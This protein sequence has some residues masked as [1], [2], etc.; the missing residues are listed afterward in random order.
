MPEQS[1]AII[2]VLG[3]VIGLGLLTFFVVST[4]SFIKIA[5]VLFI[6]RNALGIQQTPPNIIIYGIA[7]ALT[8]FVMSPVLG[9]VS[10]IVLAE[11][12]AP[13]TF[14][15][16]LALFEEAREPVRQFLIRFTPE[17]QREFFLLASQRVWPEGTA[18]PFTDTDF[19]VLIPGFLV[20][21]LQRAFE[22]GF[23]LYLPL[24]VVDLVVTTVLMAMGMSMVTPTIISTPVKLFLFVS[25]SGWTNL[26]EGLVLT[27]AT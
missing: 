20:A 11:E 19:S 1:P 4:T 17:A 8:V 18:Q 24:I 6:V 12:R 16:W 5:V 23:L 26:I 14:D 25:I 15:R 9:E 3:I 13:A 27:Y 22:I 21:E 2:G 7:L 10:A